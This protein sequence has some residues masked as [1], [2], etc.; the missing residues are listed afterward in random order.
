[1]KLFQGKIKTKKIATEDGDQPRQIM[2]EHRV[3]TKEAYFLEAIKFQ[4]CLYKD[5]LFRLV[6]TLNKT[7]ADDVPYVINLNKKTKEFWCID[8]EGNEVRV[9]S[10][11]GEPIFKINHPMLLPGGILKNCPNEVQTTFGRIMVNKVL[12]SECYGDAIPYINKMFTYRDIE[13]IV[14]PI[15]VDDGKGGPGKIEVKQ[16]KM[17]VTYGKLFK[18][19][20]HLVVYGATEKTTVAPKGIKAFKEK[21]MKNYKKPY[22]AQNLFEIETALKKFDAE[23]LADDPSDGIVMSGKMKNLSRVKS[24]LVFGSGSTLGGKVS[25]PVITSLDDGVPTDKYTR[26][27]MLDTVRGGS[28]GRGR[29]TVLGGVSSNYLQGATTHIV[30]VDKDCKTKR[31]VD[32]WLDPSRPSKWLK[33]NMM[34]GGKLVHITPE[35][36]AKY[37]G[38]V[39]RLRSPIHCSLKAGTYCRVCSGEHLYSYKDSIA[40]VATNISS[41]IMGFYMK[42]SHSEATA[43][44]KI[45]LDVMMR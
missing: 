4:V 35:V 21:L 29:S 12:L 22:T 6:V 28:E 38:K 40:L 23:W 39:V 9:E 41:S 36:L 34:V 13:D 18:C 15:L 14:A 11:I 26:A 2:K 44:A 16:Y 43:M 30:V 25:S 33:L 8:N 31:T 1:M 32:R 7:L 20:A 45:D 10:T 24:L 42:K 5:F 17:C 37:S 27:D 19:L 3:M